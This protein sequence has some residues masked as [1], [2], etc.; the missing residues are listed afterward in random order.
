MS[1]KVI[2]I[3]DST[4]ELGTELSS[5]YGIIS[6]PLHVVFDGESYDDGININLEKLYEKVEATGTLPKTSAA[7]HGEIMNF[8]TKYLEEG[9]D[10]V[11]CGISSKLSVTF[12]VAYLVSQELE[13]EFGEGRIHLVDSQ[14]LSTGIGLLL[15]KAATLRDM[16]LELKEEL[17]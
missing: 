6:F 4:S 9:Y 12:Q 2:I 10:I 15:L 5:K 13:E 17:K 14:N 8:F 11:Y 3:T 7:S 16:I 1:N